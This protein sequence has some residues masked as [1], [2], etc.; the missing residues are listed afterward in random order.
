MVLDCV[1]NSRELGGRQPPAEIQ[2]TLAFPCP[3]EPPNKARF[4]IFVAFVCFCSKLFDSILHGVR[5][6][7]FAILEL[8]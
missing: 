6:I 7:L 2:T 4:S 3:L 8:A 5:V 1:A